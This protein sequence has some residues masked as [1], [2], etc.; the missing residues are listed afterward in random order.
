MK[1]IAHF[2]VFITLMM[3]PVLSYAIED[4][5]YD[6]T[7]T[8]DSGSYTVPVEVKDGEVMHVE[9]PNGGNM[10]VSGAEL[11]GGEASGTNSRGDRV[12]IE[13]DDY[14]AG[15]DEMYTLIVE[16]IKSIS[17]SKVLPAVAGIWTAIIATIA[18]S[19]WKKQTRAHRQIEFMDQLTDTVHE[20]IQTMVAPVMLLKIIKIGIQ[21]YSGTTLLRGMVIKNA[22]VITYIEEKGKSDQIKLNE[23]LD[24]VRPIISRLDSLVTKGQVLG[25]NNYKQCYDACLMLARSYNQIEVF[26]GVIGNSHLNWENPLIQETLDRTMTIDSSNIKADI[27]NQHSVFL[28]FIK[29]TYQTLLT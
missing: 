17:W 15:G 20:Y 26:T 25:L 4:G 27:N 12:D 8:T 10:S 7:V 29:Q 1:N 18:L 28:E 5:T 14:D 24:K 2:V 22:G 19:T 13:I 11:D 9:W 21:A 6:A 16:A 3:L 23:Y